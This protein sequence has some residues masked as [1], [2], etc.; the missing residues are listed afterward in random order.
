[1][2]TENERHKVFNFQI[3]KLDSKTSNENP[4]E[5]FNNIDSAA[6]INIA[7]GF[8]LRSIETGEYRYFYAHENNT[9]FEKPLLLCTKADMITIEGKGEKID[10]V[11]QCTQKRQNTKWRVK[12]ITK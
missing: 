7:P 4:E 1:M 2:E 3:S 6:K 10:I 9:L 11:E 12:L 5:V 8:V